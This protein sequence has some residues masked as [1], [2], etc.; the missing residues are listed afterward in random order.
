GRGGAQDYTVAGDEH[1]AV[2]LG[3]EGAQLRGGR[4][5]LRLPRR[6]GVVGVEQ[7]SMGT[8][9]PG[10]PTVSAG[11][12]VQGLVRSRGIPGGSTVGVDMEHEA[13]GTDKPP[14][15]TAATSST[16]A[17]LLACAGGQQ[18]ADAQNRCLHKS[19]KGSRSRLL[20]LRK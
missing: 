12:P 11:D 10:F 8:D 4:N 19:S 9:D 13:V 3:R 1:R 5:R 20:A 15:T 17:G 18:Y 2:V 6:A 7:R 16:G 14:T